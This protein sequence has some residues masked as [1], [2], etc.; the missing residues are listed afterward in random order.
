M[1]CACGNEISA[2]RLKAVPTA[3]RCVPC[4]TLHE[5]EVTRTFPMRVIKALAVNGEFKEDEVFS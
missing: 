4:E 5:R 2:A 3:V 1:D